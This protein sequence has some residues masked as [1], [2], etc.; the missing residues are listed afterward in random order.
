VSEKKGLSSVIIRKKREKINTEFYDLISYREILEI[1]K[2]G[3][4]FVDRYSWLGAVINLIRTVNLESEVYLKKSKISKISGKQWFIK[5]LKSILEAEKN[6][7]EIDYEITGPNSYRI[8][9]L[10]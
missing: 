8:K 2:G 4:D 10:T 3:R 7:D 1:T 5:E 6:D 9:A